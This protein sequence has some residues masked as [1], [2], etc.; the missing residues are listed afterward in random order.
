V[1]RAAVALCLWAAACGGN[2]TP[3]LC[4]GAGCATQVSTRKQF[5]SLIA[6]KLDLLLVVDD[7]PAIAP[8]ADALATGFA[9]MAQRLTLPYGPSSVHAGFVRA[10]GC[11][12]STLAQACGIAAPE[13]FLRAEWCETLTNATPSVAD[14][15]TCLGGL[16][17]ADCGPIQPLAVAVRTLAS[18]AAGW[19]GFLRPDAALMVVVIATSDDASGAPGSPTAVA[20][21][22]AR[23]KALK[24][25][26]SEVLVSV[27]GP[28][29]CPGDAPP[30]RLLEL[31][32]SFGANGLIM[33]LCSAPLSAALD[34]A[35]ECISSELEPACVA[36]VR[37]TDP[38]T[39]GLQADCTVTSLSRNPD[40]STTQSVL[41]SC[42]VGAPPCW[43]F[44]PSTCTG[45]GWR[46]DVQQPPD[47]CA[48]AGVNVT[49]ECLG[50]ADA[51]D[52]AC[53]PQSQ[54]P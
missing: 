7:T 15:F 45:P 31:V 37:D 23:L 44:V 53:A 18:P 12:P 16:D 33:G 46:F 49:I 48:E 38:Q 28:G 47:W 3:V 43:R 9:G 50:C 13:Q 35:F 2:L 22:V 29:S 19:Q 6:R 21:I 20:D 34:R 25:D 24:A 39:P 41:P 4:D 51:H 42:D 14:T 1:K 26:P 52:P 17:T 36:N 11:D 32:N 54:A 40:G 10:G 8:Y 5:Q 27:I 30:P